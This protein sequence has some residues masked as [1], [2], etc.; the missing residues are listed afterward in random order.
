LWCVEPARLNP[1]KLAYNPSQPDGR[2]KLTTS[3]FI[4][5]FS[6]QAAVLIAEPTAILISI[7]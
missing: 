5:D 2:L 3:A 1:I 7:T 4:T 6:R